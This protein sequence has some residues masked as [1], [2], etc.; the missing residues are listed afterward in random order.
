MHAALYDYVIALG[1]LA[2]QCQIIHAQENAC[3]TTSVGQVE[4]I[5]SHISTAVLNISVNTRQLTLHLRG[6][7]AANERQIHNVNNGTF[8]HLNKL[9]SLIIEPENPRNFAQHTMNLE[10]EAFQGL[11]HLTYL[12]LSIRMETCNFPT[13]TFKHLPSLQVLDLTRTGLLDQD[14]LNR[15]LPYLPYVTHT[16]I[17]KNVQTLKVGDW[18]QTL[19]LSTLACSLKQTSLQVLDLSYNGFAAMETSKVIKCLPDLRELRLNDNLL[20]G[21]SGGAGLEAMRL[22]LHPTLEVL[23]VGRQWFTSTSDNNRFWHTDPPS[24]EQPYNAAPLHVADEMSILD[25]M[26]MTSI[27]LEMVTN[28]LG[29]IGDCEG[30]ESLNKC[31]N[32][33]EFF[34]FQW[35]NPT[36]SK[37]CDSLVCLWPKDFQRHVCMELLEVILGTLASQ[38]G[39]YSDCIFG[40]ALPVGP[41]LQK[42]MYNDY[43]TYQ[44]T[45]TSFLAFQNVGTFCFQNNSLEH[46][47]Y[48]G[49]R[50]FPLM[51][52]QLLNNVD[53]KGLSNLKYI[54]FE[55]NDVPLW[56]TKVFHSLPSLE[57]IKVGQ[58]TLYLHNDTNEEFFSQ[59]PFLKYLDLSECSISG[60]P[61]EEF[62][63]LTNLQELN[64][65]F[66]HLKQNSLKI[67]LEPCRQL[68]LLN[69][70]GNK[71]DGLNEYMQNQLDKHYDLEVDLSQNL[72]TCDCRNIKFI[73]WFQAA[74]KLEWRYIFF[75]VSVL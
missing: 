67:N 43:A 66:N 44:P 33:W 72:L 68:R 28:V 63:N 4:C 24:W 62:S 6:T 51:E 42:L 13:T 65:A 21:D 73:R 25:L 61:K 27:T 60:I 16:V 31:I 30:K 69:L 37:I 11:Q 53:L 9:L 71:L 8:S 32:I 34:P 3:N 10:E 48:S 1:I 45:G 7:R 75:Y 40:M 22:I 58:N 26:S 15:V 23:D 38:K 14:T 12:R 70:S 64:L 52:R 57:I 46:V 54:N 50:N 18:G 55:N 29:K 5:T 35:D 20:G 74:S 36:K 47:D 59:N 41:N 49:Y 56:N 19:D 39:C 2:V 17:L